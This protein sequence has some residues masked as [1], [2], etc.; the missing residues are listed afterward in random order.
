MQIFKTTRDRNLAIVGLVAFAL[1]IGSIYLTIRLKF[2]FLLSEEALKE[3]FARFPAWLGMLV[4]TVSH[5][6]QVVLMAIPGYA[7]AAVGGAL[8]GPVVGLGLTMI[9]VTVGSTIAFLIARRWGRPI[10]ERMIEED[11]L[12]RF[13][14]FAQSAGTPGLFL[15]VFIPVLPEDVISFVAGMAEF[16]LSTFVAVMFFGRL[17]AAA[18][19]VFAGS[20]FASGE[21]LEAGLWAMV[22]IVFSG[23]TYYYR[24]ELLEYASRL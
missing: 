12:E 21:L 1:F 15:F 22:L 10:V 18:V 3:I 9:G 6:V 16:K 17:P 8:F 5:I 20:S 19:A 4:F 2:P 7:I 11:A 23:Y 13:D 24:D 14:E